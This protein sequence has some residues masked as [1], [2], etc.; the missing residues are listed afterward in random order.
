MARPEAQNSSGVNT[1]DSLTEPVTM[2]RSDGARSVNF[3][4]AEY[5]PAW[6][7]LPAI[8]VAILLAMLV[9]WL[10]LRYERDTVALSGIALFGLTTCVMLVAA[11]RYAWLLVI[12]I[13]DW[14]RSAKRAP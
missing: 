5:R 6:W 7:V 3:R 12:E 8:G 2:D 14:R 1:L 9:I 13:S 10:G 4:L 11:V